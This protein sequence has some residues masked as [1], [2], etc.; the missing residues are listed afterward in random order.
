MA[1]E[2]LAAIETQVS[3]SG[4]GAM[5][6]RVRQFRGKMTVASAGTGTTVSALLLVPD[7]VIPN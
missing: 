2:Q 7:S 3:G 5:R 4:L 1:P 6:D